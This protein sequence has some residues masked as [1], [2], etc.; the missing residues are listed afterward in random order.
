[1]LQ[2]GTY[3][4]LTG[5][6]LKGHE[7]IG[8]G[9]A[10]HYLPTSEYETLVHHLTGLEFAEHVTQEERDEIIHEA[11]EELET[12]EAFQEIDPGT[13]QSKVGMCLLLISYVRICVQSISRRLNPY[14]V[15]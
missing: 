15:H 2:L 7:V 13:L 14:S 3:L 9:L 11:L 6:R 4:A 12:D 1:M 10:T 8:L 5:E